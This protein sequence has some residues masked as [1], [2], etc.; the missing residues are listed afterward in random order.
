[1][2]AKDAGDR[3]LPL[4]ERKKVR[5]RRALVEAALRLFIQRGFDATTVDELVDEVEVSKRTFYANFAAKEDVALAAEAELWDAYLGRVAET[6]LHGPV[7]DA[8]REILAATI[9]GL[10][11]DWARRFVATRGLIARTPAL[12][13]RSAALTFTVQGRLVERLETA[14]GIDGRHDVRLRMLGELV[15]GAWRCGARNWIAGRG[16][17]APAP[18]KVAG[19]IARVDEAF[20]A[21]P[22]TLDLQA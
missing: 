4:R 22:A 17:T 20:T 3:A 10:G 21:I 9:T 2:T 12:A 11:D 13:D 7:L 19:L 18:G 1:M 8:L 5:T 15:L 14:L 6:P 16:T